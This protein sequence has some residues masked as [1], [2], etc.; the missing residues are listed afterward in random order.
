MAEQHTEDSTADLPPAAPLPALPTR[1]ARPLPASPPPVLPPGPARPSA[2]FRLPPFSPEDP[3]LWLAQVECACRVAGITDDT[4][5]FDLLVANLPM[6][7]ATQVRDVITATPASYPALTAALRTRLA[8]SRAARLS[9]LLR[10]TQ[11]GDQ[12]PSQLL[13]L[14]RSELGD[15]PHDSALLRTLFLQRLPQAATAALSLLP[16]DSSLTQLAAAA[17]RF[18]EAS[19]SSVLAAV[20]RAGPPTPPAPADPGAVSALHGVVA[21][22]TAAVQRLEASLSDR[23]RASSR[24]R[25]HGAAG[26]DPRRRSRSR[27]RPLRQQEEQRAASDGRQQLCWY[28]SKFGAAARR[29]AEP[30][31]W[32]PP[33]GNGTA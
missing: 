23:S 4:V 15:E 9:A 5:K 12:K 33:P 21:T 22:L 32:S 30:C 27:G 25:G 29:C 1:P 11:L 19:G 7:V 17:D 13:L 6:P 31:S 18:M 8:Q 28:H 26:Y 2:A 24:D 14:M 20:H 10:N 3:A 16:E